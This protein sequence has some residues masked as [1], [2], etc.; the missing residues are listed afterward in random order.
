[1]SRTPP[2]AW[3]PWTV[4]G[5]PDPDFDAAD[6]V[7]HHRAL[8]DATLLTRYRQQFG[9]ADADYDAI[10][11]R[12]GH[13]WDC[14]ADGAANVVGFCC[15][16]C[17]RTRAQALAPAISARSGRQPRQEPGS[18]PRMRLRRRAPGLSVR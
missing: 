6:R 2:A 4:A 16:T 10:V 12:L 15:A 11:R 7:R 8:T 5:A 13:V 18:L 14:P 9:G 1:M 3:G 17:A